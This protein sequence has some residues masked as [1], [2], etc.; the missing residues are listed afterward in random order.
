MILEWV[1]RARRPNSTVWT[2]IVSPTN[3]L[4]SFIC[5]YHLD[6]ES[7]LPRLIFVSPLAI[8]CSDFSLHIKLLIFQLAETTQNSILEKM[9]NPTIQ[10]P[11]PS[12]LIRFPLPPSIHSKSNEPIAYFPPLKL[13]HSRD[14]PPPLLFP[15]VPTQQMALKGS[16]CTGTSLGAV[17]NNDGAEGKTLCHKQIATSIY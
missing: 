5:F 3:H 15:L 10:T 13:G 16:D 12:N 14:S 1:I 6:T 2:S 7:D 9:G 17:P 8:S 4:P 11:P